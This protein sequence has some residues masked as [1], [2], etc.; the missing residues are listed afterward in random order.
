ML[1]ALT[2]PDVELEGPGELHRGLEAVSNWFKQDV[3]QEHVTS[4]MAVERMVDAGERVLLFYVRQLRCRET[5]E[6]GADV[7]LAAVFVPQDG[8][9]FAW[10]SSLTT[11]KRSKLWGC[12]P[13]PRAWRVLANEARGHRGRASPSG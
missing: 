8:R 13:L 9:R 6:I 1:L 7:P 10:R 11:N 12:S 5:N 2:Y 3:S 4:Q